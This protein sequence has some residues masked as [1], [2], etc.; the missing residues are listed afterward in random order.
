M[1][2]RPSPSPALATLLT[3][4]VVASIVPAALASSPPQVACGACGEQFAR[5]AADVDIEVTVLE[6]TADVRLL[7]NGTAAWTAR[8]RVTPESA[9]RLENATVGVHALARAALASYPNGP[10]EDPTGLD[11]RLVGNTVVVT[12]TDRAPLE[13]AFGTTRL[14]YF[15]TDGADR[16]FRVNVDRLSVVTPERTRV[17]NT[18]AE[19][20]VDGRN[21]TWYGNATA[22][23]ETHL[24]HGEGRIVFA[25]TDLQNSALRT[26]AALWADTLPIY[27]DNLRAYVLPTTLLFGALVGVGLGLIRGTDRD[28]ASGLGRGLLAVGVAIALGSLVLAL[29]GRLPAVGVTIAGAVLVAVLGWVAAT[30]PDHYRAARPAARVGLVSLTGV[31]IAVIPVIVAFA[32]PFAPPLPVI[33]GTL[34]LQ[35]LPVALAPAAGVLASRSRARSFALGWALL[36]GAV[37]LAAAAFVPTDYRPFGALIVFMLMSAIAAAVVVTSLAAVGAGLARD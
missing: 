14:E 20:V 3:L 32:P 23:S 21:V 17:T 7:A 31:L 29:V 1:S 8:T 35:L 12:F 30:R 2:P 26:T 36:V 4:L 18:P 22:F 33:L 34:W 10:A 25:P 15:D 11:T 19:S 37:A 28:R 24:S 13:R 5:A 6:S 27:L 16:G 9:A